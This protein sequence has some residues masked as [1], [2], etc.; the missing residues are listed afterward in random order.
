MMKKILMLFIILISLITPV[1][2]IEGAGVVDASGLNIRTNP[3]T[4]SD[5]IN[6]IYNKQRVVVEYQDGEWYNL[7]PDGMRVCR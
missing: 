3:S 2:A 6:V 5:I 7:L 4:Q 1:Y